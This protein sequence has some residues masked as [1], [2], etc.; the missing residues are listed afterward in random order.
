MEKRNVGL[1]LRIKDI[2]KIVVGIALTIVIVLT[3]VQIC[4]F[5]KII[6]TK[7]KVVNH[8]RINKY[9]VVADSEETAI[10]ELK[11]YMKK[12]GFN[13]F[14]VS[15]NNYIFRKENIQREIKAK[16]IKTINI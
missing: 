9:F 4:P 5:A 1:K 6:L 15:N 7:E 14:E 12:E 13:F 8:K 16:D 11:K 2:K 10:E 3:T